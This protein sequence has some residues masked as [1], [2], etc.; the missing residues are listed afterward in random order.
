MPENIQYQ[1]LYDRI[2]ERL[3]I[4]EGEEI[5]LSYFDNEGVEKVVEKDEIWETVREGIQKLILVVKYA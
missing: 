1:Q 3:K 4:P 5:V 2:R